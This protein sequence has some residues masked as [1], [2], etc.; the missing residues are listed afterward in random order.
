[1]GYCVLEEFIIFIWDRTCDLF[2]LDIAQGFLLGPIG[3]LDENVNEP[4]LILI[5]F[6]RKE[7]G[8]KK[9]ACYVQ[10]PRVVALVLGKRYPIYVIQFEGRNKSLEQ[11]I[12]E[13]SGF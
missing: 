13:F 8:G 1:M 6:N 3:I 4:V 10:K 5:R 7:E 9:V 2:S 12:N 11:W